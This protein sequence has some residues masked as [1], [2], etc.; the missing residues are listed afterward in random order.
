MYY[1]A[2]GI[3]FSVSDRPA[4]ILREESVNLCTGQPPTDCD[5]TRCCIIQFE[6][7]MMSTTLLERCRGYNKLITK[8]EFV[9]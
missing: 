9:N 8:Q 1:T 4:R 6:L 5:D 3:V 2:S 7:L